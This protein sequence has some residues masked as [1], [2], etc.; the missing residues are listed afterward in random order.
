MKMTD[1]LPGSVLGRR[2]CLGIIP[3]THPLKELVS[4]KPVRPLSNLGKISPVSKLSC[5][6]P[7]TSQKEFPS[8][9]GI[10]FPEEKLL[11]STQSSPQ[12]TMYNLMKRERAA[13][14][15]LRLCLKSQS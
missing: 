8:P 9:S 1:P 15:M 5:K 4:S 2:K 6:L 3:P 14:E 12:C 7:I 11:I 10:A 13:W